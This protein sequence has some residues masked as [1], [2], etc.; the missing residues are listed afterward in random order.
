MM[1]FFSFLMLGFLFGLR[2]AFD[3][4][5]IAALGVLTHRV[6]HKREALLNSLV[7]ALGHAVII[8][9]AGAIFYAFG[10]KIPQQFSGFFEAVVAV[11]LI[12]LGVFILWSFFKSSR[13]GSG[14]FFTHYHPPFGK[15]GHLYPSFFIGILHGL[16]GSAAISIFL[17]ATFD[18][19]VIG[20]LYLLS[21]SLGIAMGAGA[22]CLGIG[23]FA[24]VSKKYAAVACGVFSIISG[25]VMLTEVI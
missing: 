24:R 16:A 25:T 22:V 19:F 14:V 4:D 18:S 10:Q 23:F 8:V 3:A 7:W 2:H 21:L 11:I 5:H 9:A 13:S 17:V 6:P 1:N 12:A 15:H 20:F